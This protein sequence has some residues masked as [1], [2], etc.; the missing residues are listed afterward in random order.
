MALRVR[1]RNTRCTQ[2]TGGA[3]KEQ[4]GWKIGERGVR[5]EKGP[6]VLFLAKA[7]AQQS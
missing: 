1:A 2:G 3:F 7:R 5:R 4:V 6:W